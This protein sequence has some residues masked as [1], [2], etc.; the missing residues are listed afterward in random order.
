METE[1][2]LLRPWRDSDAV[3]DVCME[4]D[5]KINLDDKDAS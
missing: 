1:R 4:P 2:I 5:V 3:D